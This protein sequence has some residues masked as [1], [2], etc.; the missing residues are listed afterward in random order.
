[1]TK[2]KKIIL[3]IATIFVALLVYAYLSLKVFN[4]FPSDINLKHR[5]GQ[6][7]ATFSKKYCEELGLNWQE[8]YLAILDD[9]K[10][11]YL[12]LPAYWDEIEKDEGVYDFEDFDYMV[13][14]ASLRDAKLIINL[15]RRQPRWP[16]CHSPAWINK[17]STEEAQL[18]LLKLVKETVL[19]YKDNSHV[20]N[21]QVE[22]EAFLGTFGVCPPLDKTFLTQEIDLVHSLDSRPVIITG[23]GEMSSW[24]NEISAGDIFGTTMYRVVYNSWAG[25]IRYFWPASFYNIKAYLAGTNPAKSLIIELQT[26]PWVPQGKMVY[27]TT[28]QINKSM[29]VDQFKANLQYAINAQFGQ[30]YVWGVEWWYWENLYGNSEYW[31]IG[32]TLFN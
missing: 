21:W 29:S 5:S 7:G 28:D 11:R 19:R 22:N 12:R 15:G 16:E 25:Y 14:Q 6:F 4:H 3:I 2:K 1:M 13:D 24:R 27:L 31:N 18:S 20:T 23:S 32:K 17:K 9:L 30:I 26:E 8:T 10:V